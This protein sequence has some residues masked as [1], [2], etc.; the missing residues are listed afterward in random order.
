MNTTIST[1][2]GDAVSLATALGVLVAVFQLWQSIRLRRTE[3]EDRIENEYR[4]LIRNLPY[5]VFL[6]A[7]LDEEMQK[8][9]RDEFYRYFDFCNGQT[10]QRRRRRIG[11]RTWDNWKDGIK[12]NLAKP[13][14][15]KAFEQILK[16]NSKTFSELQRLVDE[17]FARDPVGWRP[18]SSKS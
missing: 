11:W 4:D 15:K 17:D 3:F 6:A 16:D 1:M 13:S 12:D 18:R 14:F 7:S 2:L 5:E 8:N 10:I 9:L